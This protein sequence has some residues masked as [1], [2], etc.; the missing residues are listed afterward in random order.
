MSS[1]PTCSNT[2]KQ[3]IEN[4]ESSFYYKESLKVVLGSVLAIIP[5]LRQTEQRQKSLKAHWP[6]N[7]AKLT[8]SRFK[9]TW[10]ND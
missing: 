8:T 1:R 3:K 9:R 10:R 4:R 7:L 6:V 5:V 2:T